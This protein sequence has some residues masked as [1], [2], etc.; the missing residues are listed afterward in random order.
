VKSYDEFNDTTTFELVNLKL[1]F[2]AHLNFFITNE[3]KY[4]LEPNTVVIHFV[5]SSSNWQFLNYNETILLIDNKRYNLGSPKHNGSVHSGSV[6]EQLFYNVS[7]S[8][9]KKLAYAKNV[10]LRVGIYEYKISTE[11]I[12]KIRE[13]YEKIVEFTS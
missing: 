7:F 5:N 6:L 9:I 10:K 3:G 11:N 12:A 13:Y 8:F 1:S 2:T 4:I